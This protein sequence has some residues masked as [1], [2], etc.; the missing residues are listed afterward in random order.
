MQQLPSSGVATACVFINKHKYNW[1]HG[2][3]LGERVVSVWLWHILAEYCCGVQVID[4]LHR[5]SCNKSQKMQAVV[6]PNGQSM[7]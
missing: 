3:C 6:L 2:N 4:K 1:W 5:L 7:F